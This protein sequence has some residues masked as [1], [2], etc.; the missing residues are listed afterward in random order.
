MTHDAALLARRFRLGVLVAAVLVLAVASWRTIARLRMHAPPPE[1]VHWYGLGEAALREATDV[2]AI[3]ALQAAV[4]RDPKY[5]MAH[6]RLAEALSDLDF[7]AEAD[8]EMLVAQ[9]EARE[10]RMSARDEK[11]LAATQATLT[12]DYAGAVR[13]YQGLLDSAGGDDRAASLVDLGRAQEKAGDSKDAMQAYQ[14]AAGLAPDTPAP[15]VHIGILESRMQ[16]EAAAQA[17][18]ALAEKVYSAETNQEG[19]AEVEYQQGYLANEQG[20]SAEAKQHLEKARTMA[21]QL[22][23]VQLEIRALTQLSSVAADSSDQ[24]DATEYAQQAIDMANANS[25]PAWSAEGWVRLGD[26]YLHSSDAADKA[27]AEDDFQRALAIAKQSEQRR[28]EAQAN[29]GLANLSKGNPDQVI[30]YAQPALDYYKQY[31]FSEG[32]VDSAVFLARAQRD[33]DELGP[34]MDSAKYL[35]QV[36]TDARSKPQVALSQDLM[37]SIYMRQQDYPA[38]AKFFHEALENSTAALRPYEASSYAEALA[39]MGDSAAAEQVRADYSKVR[40]AADFDSLLITLYSIE[41]KYGQVFALAQTSPTREEWITAMAVASAHLGRTE[42]AEAQMATVKPASA[43]DKA[44]WNLAEAEVELLAANPSKAQ[45]SADAALKYFQTIGARESEVKALAVSA[46]ALSS[47]GAKQD[48]GRKAKTGLDILHQLQE[49]WS[50]TDYA[51]FVSRPDM[52]D[53][54]QMLNA[55]RGAQ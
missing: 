31:G 48:A 11:Y 6:A 9:S 21:Q 7:T 2:K 14:Q 52:Q 27:K 29:V 25:L 12:R 34:A 43:A 50:P 15:F 1:A 23:S 4:D 46:A 51:S 40:S 22:K 19:L 37:A 42:A 33:K 41:G 26:V 24:K 20:K 13:R 49:S 45:S 35:L 5:A 54:T 8:H 44:D 17:A 30:A 10:Q 16:H 18:F 39:D 36:A 28:V 53:A 38:A 32:M 55:C 3:H 47:A